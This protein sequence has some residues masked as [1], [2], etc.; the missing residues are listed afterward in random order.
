MTNTQ[1]T[2][3]YHCASTNNDLTVVVPGA[4][5]DEQIEALSTLMIDGHQII[6]PQVGLPSPLEQ[7]IDDGSI[8]GCDDTDH[9]LTTLEA[10]DAERLPAATDLHTDAE[11]T[12]N[13]SIDE[14]EGRM[15]TVSWD[16]LS[17][18]ERL[19]IPDEDLDEADRPGL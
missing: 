15:K 3:S 14:L 1:L 6:A 19:G 13:M 2:L 8:I 4:I 16:Q 18:T 17:E 11:P 12:V 7:L 5:T 10:W 9:P